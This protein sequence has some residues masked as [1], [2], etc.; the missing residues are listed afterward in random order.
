MNFIIES[1]AFRTSISWCE[2][3]TQHI[4]WHWIL[5]CD[6][7]LS[8]H[9]HRNL[10]NRYIRDCTFY[11]PTSSSVS[12]SDDFCTVVNIR[13]FI[14]NSWLVLITFRTFRKHNLSNS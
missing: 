11:W 2:F 5:Y 14:G 8:A 4:F 9:Q 1:K 10:W 6:R 7:S 3:Q 13:Q 12:Q